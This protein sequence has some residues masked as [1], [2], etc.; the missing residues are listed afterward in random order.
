MHYERDHEKLQ[1]AAAEGK[2]VEGVEGIYY[3]TLVGLT[4]DMSRVK[5]TPAAADGETVLPVIRMCRQCSSQEK[6]CVV[7]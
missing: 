4:P 2:S 1:R 5:P 3:Q 6:A 7:F